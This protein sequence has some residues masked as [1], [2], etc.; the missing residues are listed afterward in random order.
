MVR[1]PVRVKIFG[2]TFRIKLC[3]LVFDLN[4]QLLSEK[5]AIKSSLSLF[6]CMSDKGVYRGG[7][8]KI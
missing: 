2:K 8:L 6:V 1:K 5:N 7:Y 4:L 3:E